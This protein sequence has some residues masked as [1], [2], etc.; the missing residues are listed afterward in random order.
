MQGVAYMYIGAGAAMVYR[1]GQL[2][3]G[4]SARSARTLS[5]LA[6]FVDVS[7]LVP[8]KRLR[9][10]TCANPKGC[11]IRGESTRKQ[12]EGQGSCEGPLHGAQNPNGACRMAERN[13]SSPA[14][15]RMR[16]FE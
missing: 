6:I 9:G 16:D 15:F 4:H 13:P 7:N 8:H 12:E 10:W 1:W 3:E 2:T 5:G 14:S 11:G